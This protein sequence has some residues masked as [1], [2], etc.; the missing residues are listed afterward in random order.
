MTLVLLVILR[1]GVAILSFAAVRA[2]GDVSMAPLPKRVFSTF[3]I[4]ANKYL[5]I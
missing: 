3:A 5:P 4:T 2:F 1:E